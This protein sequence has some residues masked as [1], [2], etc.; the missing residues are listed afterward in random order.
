MQEKI[1]TVINVITS[2]TIQAQSK[3]AQKN[4]IQS[5]NSHLRLIKKK[6]VPQ[7][8]VA[9]KCFINIAQYAEAQKTPRPLE[10]QFECEQR[11]AICFG[12]V[13]TVKTIRSGFVFT[14]LR[15]RQRKLKIRL[16]LRMNAAAKYR[17][18]L[19]TGY[20][21]MCGAEYLPCNITALIKG[22]V[23]MFGCCPLYQIFTDCLHA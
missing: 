19:T 1:E 7:D 10:R 9:V 22:D 2:S 3:Q 17:H 4:T 23:L 15:F 12:H 14:I 13:Q 20:L 18:I 6:Q 21:Y 5:Q 8:P 11:A 16:F